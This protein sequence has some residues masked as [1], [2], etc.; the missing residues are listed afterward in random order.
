MTHLHSNQLF[1]IAKK[2]YSR[3][4]IEVSENDSH[5]EGAISSI[6]F[7]CIA[8]EAFTN[9]ISALAANR[10]DLCKQ[11]NRKP[12]CELLVFSEVMTALNNQRASFLD[13]IDNAKRLATGEEF[14][15]GE[16]PYQDLVLLVQLRNH[17]VHKEATKSEIKDGSVLAVGFEKLR[18][19]CQERKILTIPDDPRFTLYDA[20]ATKAAARWACNTASKIVHEF[21]GKCIDNYLAGHIQSLFHSGQF[22]LIEDGVGVSNEGDVHKENPAPA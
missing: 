7:S 13:R 21:K 5:Q 17:I 1:S 10:V 11:T 9:D 8:L 16:L 14:V 22:A 6:V 4:P 15:R 18:D 2:A 19:K 12:G 20:M 3:I